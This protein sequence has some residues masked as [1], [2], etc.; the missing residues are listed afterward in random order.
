MGEGEKLNEAIEDRQ[1]GLSAPPGQYVAVIL[2]EARSKQIAPDGGPRR[3]NIRLSWLH[4]PLL[5]GLRDRTD[6][7]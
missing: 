4:V 1:I 3:C 6:R 7:T 5:P 2:L